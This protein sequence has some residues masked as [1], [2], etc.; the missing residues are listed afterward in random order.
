VKPGS[1]L[2]SGDPFFIFLL[3]YMLISQ[4]PHQYRADRIGCVQHVFSIQGAPRKVSPADDPVFMPFP[5]VWNV[6]SP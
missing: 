1:I 4:L 2:F 3:Q 6:F 5:C